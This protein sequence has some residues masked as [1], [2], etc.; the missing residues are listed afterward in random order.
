MLYI[1]GLYIQGV[2]HSRCCI[3][4]VLYIHVLYIQGVV[5]SFVVHPRCCTSLVVHSRFCTNVVAPIIIHDFP[6]KVYISN[7]GMEDTSK[8]EIDEAV[9]KDDM[10]IS[11]MIHASENEIWLK[12][13]MFV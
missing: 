6:K 5:Y 2:V 11:G 10:E 7:E 3:F 12:R 4:K 1:Q 13:K 9:G 8:V